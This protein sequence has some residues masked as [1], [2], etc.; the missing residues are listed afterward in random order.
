[1]SEKS[2]HAKLPDLAGAGFAVA[3]GLFVLVESQSYVMGS[4]RDMGPG[5]FPGMFAI[6]L[7]VLG[8]LLAGV[9]LFSSTV[10]PK[11]TFPRFFSVV[12]IIAAFMAFALLIDRFGLLPAIFAAV[13][14]STFASANAHIARSVVLSAVTAAGC[15][16]LF[17]AVLGLPIKV[18][19]L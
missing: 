16:I 17:V 12:S 10:A 11:A 15:S 14:L 7:I 13:F 19:A 5:Y 8:C 6:V 1:M 2:L 9:T 4:L 18:F 3:L